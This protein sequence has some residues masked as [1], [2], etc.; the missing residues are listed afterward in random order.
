M[1]I[2]TKIKVGVRK[3]LTD[4]DLAEIESKRIIHGEDYAEI[5]KSE[6]LKKKAQYVN[7]LYDTNRGILMYESV[8]IKDTITVEDTS[9]GKFTMAGSIDEVYKN[10]TESKEYFE[11]G[12]DI[13]LIL[14]DESDGLFDIE[15]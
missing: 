3:P 15:E 1:V 10:M 2:K 8:S 14:E 5:V 9:L 11:I 7:A 13:E 6:K 4:E 12:T